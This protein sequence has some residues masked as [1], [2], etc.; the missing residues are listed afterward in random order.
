MNH[1]IGL[2]GAA[3]DVLQSTV[4]EDYLRLGATPQLRV[5]LISK[6]GVV[7]AISRP[8][9][10]PLAV[11]GERV[12]A[13]VVM[14]PGVAPDGTAEAW[15]EIQM[16]RAEGLSDQEAWQAAINPRYRRVSAAQ[17][18]GYCGGGDPTDVA[19][20]KAILVE[21][22]M[23][24]PEGRRT[25]CAPTGSGSA[26]QAAIETRGL[27]TVAATRPR[28]DEGAHE[29]AQRT[30]AQAFACEPVRAAAR[31]SRDVVVWMPVELEGAS[32]L[33]QGETLRVALVNSQGEVLAE[34]LAIN[35]PDIRIPLTAAEF[36]RFGQANRAYTLTG[37]I[38]G[39][40][41]A[42]RRVADTTT[43]RL[44][45]GSQRAARNMTATLSF[46]GE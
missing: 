38:R 26:L 5:H 24:Q 30:M 45:A 10:G 32:A 3:P 43:V 16:M 21:A 17:F 19:F 7:K 12:R 20:C 28:A 13:D 44:A 33:G 8:A 37:E 2:P 35:A 46:G 25:V 6:E 27:A 1:V 40:D 15:R 42:V 9:T 23:A 22:V 11:E 18:Q 34:T 39:A 36:P 4:A 14:T 41:G 29:Y 31:A